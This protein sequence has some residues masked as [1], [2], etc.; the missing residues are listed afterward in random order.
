MIRMENFHQKEKLIKFL[1]T[2]L[3]D[4]KFLKRNHQKVQIK[5]IF[6]ETLK[7]FA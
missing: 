6:I 1:L 4:N 7:V 2:K 3:L 5:K